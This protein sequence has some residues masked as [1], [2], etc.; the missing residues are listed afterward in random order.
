MKARVR[1]LIRRHDPEQ[2]LVARLGAVFG[3]RHKDRVGVRGGWHSPKHQLGV[4]RACFEQAPKCRSMLGLQWEC[5][6]TLAAQLQ[7]G[8]A[9]DGFRGLAALLMVQY[10][11]II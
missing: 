3:A 5:A 4:V 1:R 8:F 6:K 7:R 10:S 9:H 11:Y 2:D